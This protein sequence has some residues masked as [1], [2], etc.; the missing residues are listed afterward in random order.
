MRIA[1][2][3][4]ALAAVSLL[5]ASTTAPASATPVHGL[6]DPAY[7]NAVDNYVISVYEDLFH[8]APELSGEVTWSTA[9]MWGTPRIAVAN[10]ITSSEEFRTGLIDDAYDTYLGRGPDAGGLQSWLRGMSAGMTVEQARLGLHR[11]AG[12]LGD[13]RRDLRGLGE[14]SVP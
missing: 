8:R 4:L 2:K 7:S 5:V 14:G 10:A 13:Q 3:A 1:H 12:V 6:F 9:L 11:L